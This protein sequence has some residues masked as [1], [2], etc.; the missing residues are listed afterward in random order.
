[1]GETM[2]DD[3][4]IYTKATEG[5]YDGETAAILSI[6]QAEAVLV[7]VRGGTQGDGFSVAIDV[8]KAEVSEVLSS[9]PR[10][11]RSIADSIER[12]ELE[13]AKGLQ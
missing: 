10:V 8:R 4:E 3:G 2:N 9:L 6:V 1:M 5:K 13:K 12:Q 7:A 11:L